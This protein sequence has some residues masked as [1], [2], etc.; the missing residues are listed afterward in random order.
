MNNQTTLTETVVVI[1]PI[2][3]TEV[4]PFGHSGM[5]LRLVGDASAQ[6]VERV[7][8]SGLKELGH[9]LLDE[10]SEGYRILFESTAKALRS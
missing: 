8:A 9:A 2:A 1:T 10:T 4:N 7:V 3:V 5:F 6:D